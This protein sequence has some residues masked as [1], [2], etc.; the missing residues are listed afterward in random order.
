MSQIVYKDMTIGVNVFSG[1]FHIV[2]PPMD[3]KIKA[4]QLAEMIYPVVKAVSEV[5][6]DRFRSDSNG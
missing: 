2:L 6:N 1:V 5:P 3:I 4:V